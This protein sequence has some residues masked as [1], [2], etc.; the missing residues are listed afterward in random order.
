MNFA[1]A[2]S[3]HAPRTPKRIFFGRSPLIGSTAIPGSSKQYRSATVVSQARTLDIANTP[4][5][6]RVTDLNICYRSGLR[7]QDPHCRG[8]LEAYPITLQ[9]LPR[10]SETVPSRWLLLP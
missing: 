7:A 1:V 5:L 8:G 4:S 9:P 10:R 6:S 3:L 2:D